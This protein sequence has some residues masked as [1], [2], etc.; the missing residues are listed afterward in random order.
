MDHDLP[1]IR[2]LPLPSRLPTAVYDLAI[3]LGADPKSAPREVRLTQS[4]R[5]KPNLER[6]SS[7]MS[8]TAAQTISTHACAFD[9]LAHAGPFGLV[10]ARDALAHGKGRLDIMALGWIPIARAP[11]NVALLR[12]ELMR[13]LAEL[14]L[15]PDAILHNPELRWREIGPDSLAVSAGSGESESEVVLSLDREGRIAGAFSPDRPRSA[16]VPFLP[17]PWRGRFTDYRLHHDRWLPF[18]AEVGWEIAGQ[19]I[20]YW[21]GRMNQWELYPPSPTE[22]SRRKCSSTSSR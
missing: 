20:V 21:Q 16:T 22:G 7:W 10:S 1:S 15:A 4:G 13:Y 11:H 14:P 19:E 12:G 8:F 5:M 2:I 9:W 17:T 3:R 18:G 6:A